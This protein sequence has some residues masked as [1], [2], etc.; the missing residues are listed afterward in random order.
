MAAKEEFV[1]LVFVDPFPPAPI[2]IAYAAPEFKA[3][4]LAVKNPPAPPLAPPP[5]ATTR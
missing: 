5:P 1:P 2:V 4:P 3:I